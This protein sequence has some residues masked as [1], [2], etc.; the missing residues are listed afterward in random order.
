MTSLN[1]KEGLDKVEACLPNN[2]AVAELKRFF[3]LIDAYGYSNWVTFTPSIVR[4]LVYYTGVVFE[5]FDRRFTS[6]AIFGGGRYDELM[7]K[8]GSAQPIPMAGFGFG[9]C[10]IMDVLKDRRCIPNIPPQ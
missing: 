2:P 10:V 4:G 6:R 3:E 5:A 7:T 8:F 9:D 1:G